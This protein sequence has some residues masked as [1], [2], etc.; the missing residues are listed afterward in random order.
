[1]NASEMIGK[2]LKALEV[3]RSV[4]EVAAKIGCSRSEALDVMLY[5]A[6]TGKITLTDSLH[7][8]WKVR[9]GVSE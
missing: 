1:M 6:G 7:S 2:V 8:R 5:L 4:D 9:H 3:E